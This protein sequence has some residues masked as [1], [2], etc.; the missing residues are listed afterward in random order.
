MKLQNVS[1]DLET[2]TDQHGC[3]RRA[4]KAWREKCIRQQHT[5]PKEFKPDWQEFEQ[6]CGK[7]VYAAFILFCR[8]L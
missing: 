7:K 6:I 8:R 4:F 3:C 1:C 2:R 5:F